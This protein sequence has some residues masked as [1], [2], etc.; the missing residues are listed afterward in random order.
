MFS[1]HTR[2]H[3]RVIHVHNNISNTISE[4]EDIKADPNK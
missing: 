2:V 1:L 4:R 3:I